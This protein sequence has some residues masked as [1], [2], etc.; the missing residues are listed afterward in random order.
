MI[1]Y[2]Y[3]IFALCIYSTSTQC[4]WFSNPLSSVREKIPAI[5]PLPIGS[6]K[7]ST[8]HSWNLGNTPTITLNTHRGSITVYS[9]Q[10]PSTELSITKRGSSRALKTTP[11]QIAHHQNTLTVTTDNSCTAPWHVSSQQCAH[12]HYTLSVPERALL[13]L[14]I[15]DGS[16]L[17]NDH[18]GD[19]TITSAHHSNIKIKNPGGAVEVKAVRG[20]VHISAPRESVTIESARAP[21]TV[22]NA[23]NS[24]TIGSYSGDIKLSFPALDC[25]TI[26]NV[27]SHSGS[28]FITLPGDSNAHLNA[29]APHG[30]VEC[31][32]P[33]TLAES[34]IVL[35]RRTVK[36]FLRS[37]KGTLGTGGAPLNL[38]TQRGKII[39]MP[40]PDKQ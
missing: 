17:T 12:V 4:Y 22:I 31:H 23:C 28:I 40:K 5:P 35:H 15:G 18:Q 32:V 24:V 1:Y 26:T 8:T 11:V 2:S 3:I 10:K 20:S 37:V 33:I 36:E 14:S 6:Q 38:F 9:H 25:D 39:I 27:K 29:S 34:T 21:I 13:K 16:V 19:Q 7:N 30:R